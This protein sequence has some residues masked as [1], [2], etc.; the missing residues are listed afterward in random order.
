VKNDTRLNVTYRDIAKLFVKAL[1]IEGEDFSDTINQYI[2]T[3]KKLSPEARLALKSAY[4]FSSKV[5][6]D[7][8]ED[9]FQTLAMTLIEA[10]VKDEKLAYTIARCDWVNWYKKF[11][12]R[13]HFSLDTVVN[14]D[15]EEET[16]Y[17]ELLVG[18]AEFEAKMNG[19]LDGA[20]LYE[21]LP[22]WVKTIVDKRLSGH[23]ITGGERIML[24]KWIAAQP[25]ILANYVN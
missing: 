22:S 12:T 25:L 19:E 9:M 5:P 15:T 17:V 14:A 3:I 6:R 1:P 2:E 11:K 16:C 21:A 10:K 20:R 8:R 18:E 4:I 23:S 7:E 13:E 24:N